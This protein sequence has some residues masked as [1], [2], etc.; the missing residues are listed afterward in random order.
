M[1]LRHTLH[2]V[3]LPQ[4]SIQYPDLTLIQNVGWAHN[5]HIRKNIKH[6]F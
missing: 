1:I 4:L 2:A 6:N 3:Y 5:K